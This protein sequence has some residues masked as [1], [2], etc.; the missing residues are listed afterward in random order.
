[1]S[2]I[3]TIIAAMHPSVLPLVVVLLGGLFIYR[4]TAISTEVIIKDR[5]ATKEQRDKDYQE[6]K[7][8][9]IKLEFKTTQIQGR[10]E[11]HDTVI[12]D[13]TKQIN[14]LNTNIAILTEKLEG[15]TKTLDELKSERYRGSK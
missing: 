5:E 15:L 1:M 4:K 6:L 12:A 7:D 8:K 3:A 11:L 2:E 13:I 9:V 10:L 14:L